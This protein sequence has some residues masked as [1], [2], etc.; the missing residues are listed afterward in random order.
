[1]TRAIG[2]SKINGGHNLANDLTAA[3]ELLGRDPGAALNLAQA[4]LRS[5]PDP[6]VFRI[7]A[8]A[9]RRLGLEAD[10]EQ[11]ELAA[12]QAAFRL[13]ELDAAAVAASEGKNF[14]AK[15]IVDRFLRNEPED[16]LA[17]TMAA[18]ADV[19]AWHLKRA[20]DRLRVVL[21]RAPKFLRAIMLLAECLTLQARIAEAI[22]V[23][24]QVVGRKP[25][26]QT[27]LQY[28]AQLHA[29]ANNHEAT[30]EIY[31]RIL[32]LKPDQLDLWIIYA[33][34][35]RMLARKEDA[36]AA[37]RQA[38]ARDPNSGASWWGLA[39][40]FASD[41]TEVDV[42]AMRQALAK[43]ADSP[44]DGGPLHIALSIIAERSGDHAQAFRHISAGKALREKLDPYDP[45][46]ATADVDRML[47][48][49]APERFAALR[50]CGFP[51]GSPIFIIGMPRSGST[52][53]ERI[54]SCHSQVEAGGELP[55]MPRLHERLRREIGENYPERV[56]AMK[57]NQLKELGA[58]YVERS[59]D[60]R[61]TD[62]PRFIDKLNS[63]WFHVG[64]IR[65]ML[66]NARILDIRR[67]A[68]DCC[69]SNY[70]MLFAEGHV[71]AN[72]MRHIARFY[73]DY[74]RLV[75]GIERA[76]PGGILRVQY[77][78]LVE[79]IETVARRIFDFLRLEFEPECID[80]HLVQ[81]AVATPSSEQVRR[82][83]N[84]DSIGSANPYRQW[85]GPMIEELGEL[86]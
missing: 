13:P 61:A 41:L 59:R 73:R 65:L 38:L 64:L 12:I 66:P 62:K 37:F 76:S 44:Q 63:N 60:Y 52:L 69:W 85:L 48:T 47:R 75:A 30:A 39:N 86:A 78:E 43:R 84:R 40:Y 55:I 54:L 5:A 29:E 3:R 22:E 26:N 27:V 56:I 34:H 15:A 4:L 7:A 11:A 31:G 32:E 81:A 19:R 45:D 68:L 42:D 71:A 74:V 77:E 51:D 46:V 18:E 16:L 79:D 6:R 82:P 17:L 35:L 70:K 2:A 20:E 28:L 58:W 24:E 23:I 53:L 33:Q 80:F 10:A 83:L 1:M 8:A 25:K 72:D 49:Y 14:E 9:C 67:N 36:K 21:G 50:S 57:P